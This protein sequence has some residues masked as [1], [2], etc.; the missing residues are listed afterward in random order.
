MRVVKYDD[1]VKAV[2]AMVLHTATN[3]PQDALDA[4]KKRIKRRRVK[5][6]KQF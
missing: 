6:Q 1:I 5:L 3:L 2:K 4:L